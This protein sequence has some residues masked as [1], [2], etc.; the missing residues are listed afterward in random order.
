MKERRKNKFLAFI[1]R[2]KVVSTVIGLIL[3]FALTLGITSVVMN[4]VLPKDVI[5]PNL[6]GLSKEEAQSKAEELKLEFE[7][8][9]ERYDTEVEAGK[10]MTQEPVYKEDYKIKEK[11]KITVVVSLGQKIVKVPK[12][13]GMTLE[14]ATSALEKEDLVVVIEEEPSKKLRL[15]M[16]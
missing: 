13:A 9:E 11:S 5:M 16:L 3:L 14:E 8:V 12:V 7:V 4:A 15:D 6:V 10:V 1:G 2:H